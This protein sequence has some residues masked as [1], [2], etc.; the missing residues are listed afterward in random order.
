MYEENGL[1]KMLKI[2]KPA[3]AKPKIPAEAIKEI[4][5]ILATEKGFRTYKEIYQLVV[6][7]YQ[8]E[9]GYSGVHNLVRYKLEAKMKS[10]R[11]SNP[12]KTNY[13][14]RNSEMELKDSSKR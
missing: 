8:T 14:S 3:G 2:Y 9:V 12:K 4:S 11:P 13:K 6:K 1:E 5:E 7:K 10:P